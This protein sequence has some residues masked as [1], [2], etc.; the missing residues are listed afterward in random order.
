IVEAR[1]PEKL[2]IEEARQADIGRHAAQLRRSTVDTEELGDC[3]LKLA[4][5]R[6]GIVG[7][8]I[9]V[10]HGLH[11]SLA[12]TWLAYDHTTAVILNCRRENFRGGSRAAIDENAQRPLPGRRRKIIAFNL[13][14]AVC[15]AL[16]DHWPLADE[17]TCQINRLAQRTAAIV[18]QIDQNAI[19][20]ILLQLGDQLGDI[21]AGA[22]VVIVA[23]PPR[24]NI[25][26]ECR[27]RNHPDLAGNVSVLYG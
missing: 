11:G 8:F 4:I 22:P 23:L 6:F 2:Q 7:H 3:K 1:F 21:A 12:E 5:F 9:K 10:D 13:D 26:V 19:Y 25:F 14:F 18:A 16:L 17:Q 20:L 15:I 27:E 24:L